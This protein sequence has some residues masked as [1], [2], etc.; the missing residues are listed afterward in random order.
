MPEITPSRVIMAS[1][2]SPSDRDSIGGQLAQQ[3]KESNGVHW[4]TVVEVNDIVDEDKAAAGP[5]PARGQL[6]SVRVERDRVKSHGRSELQRVRVVVT[7]HQ[8]AV[9][10]HLSVSL[11]A[12]GRRT[13]REASW[14]RWLG[15]PF[16]KQTL[17]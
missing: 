5:K 1:P 3:L 6:V 4:V 7:P 10:V 17:G 14:P 11:S 2:Q 12:A 16:P 13:D 15:R 9:T 8:Q